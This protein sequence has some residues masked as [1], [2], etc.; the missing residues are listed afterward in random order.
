M[1]T[2]CVFALCASAGA[3]SLRSTPHAPEGTELHA[4]KNVK[5]APIGEGAY[6]SAEAVME[7]TTSK[8]TDCED[9]KWADCYK[10]EG[11]YL[12]H[13]KGA[14]AAQLKGE[15][16]NKAAFHA[17]TNERQQHAPIGEGAYQSAEAVMERTTSKNT[18]CEDGKWADC[19]KGEGDYLDHKK[20]ASAAQVKVEPK[21]AAA[22]HAKKSEK[23]EHTPIGEGAYQSAE[24]VMERT[25]SKN[26]DCEDGKWANCYKG[27]GDY[28][29]H[30]KGAS[31]AQVKVEPKNTADLHV[32]KSEKQ[33]HA[34]IGEG[35]YQSAEAV[36]ERTT[37]KNTDCED[38]KWADCYKGEGD[39]LD[40]K[41]GASV[42]QVKVEPKT[43]ALHAEKSEKQKHAP[44]GEG[45]YQSAEAVMERTTSKNTDCED[46]KWADCYKG[47]GDYLDHKKG[48]SA[49]QVKVEPNNA[50]ALHANK[51]EKQ[52]HA[53]V[54]EGAYQSAEAV[55]ERTTSKNTDC[56]DGKWADCYKGE[57]D[58]LDHKK[59]AS[60]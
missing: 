4:E 57:G 53:P 29:D 41:K 35:A 15:P 25:T 54:G 5:H 24:A 20:S 21:T 47:E 2:V 32:K 56:E 18:D 40:H 33:H 11:D 13:K 60:M 36:M 30:K 31:A 51:S 19:Y 39:Y 46:G 34:P 48:A 37:S 22:L 58:Y 50:A 59:G 17:K 49:A 3:L 1:K 27:E 10:G 12:D 55:M 6:Q 7:R 23:Q 42:A 28:L 43:A 26:T 44:I 16:K 9:G 8:N 38:G 52:E 45:A 14:S